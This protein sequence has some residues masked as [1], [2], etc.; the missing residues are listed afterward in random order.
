MSEI[1]GKSP[2]RVWKYLLVTALAGVL[3]A[4]GVVWYATTDSFQAM[5][6]RRLVTELEKI[7]GGRVEIGSFHTIPFRLRVEV[8][9]ITIHGRESADEV[10]YAHADS[11]GAQVKIISVLG[12]ELGF[13][14]LV[15]DH[16][17]VHI[18][19]YPDGSNNQPEP[20]VQRAYEKAPV[21][22]LFSLSISQLDVRDGELVW[23][24]QRIPLDF[25]A[26]D[27][28]ASMSYALFRRRYDGHIAVGKVDSR[29]TD[30]RPFAWHAE[31]D[32]SL[33]RRQID[34]TSFKWSSG[35][36]HLEAHGRLA[37]FQR[38]KIEAD[39]TGTL[40]LA[41]VASILRRRELRQG[42][43]DVQGRGEWSLEEFSSQG[44]FQLR[45]L[46]WRD[47][48]VSLRGARLNSEF[49][50]TDK[51][52]K[53][54]QMQARAFG[55]SGVGD[56][57]VANWLSPTP[58][59]QPKNAKPRKPAEEQRGLLRLR[60]KGLSVTLVAAAFTT[61]SR[62]FDR[63][64]L[65]G[66][67]DATIDARWQGSIRDTEVQ[68]ALDV[69]PPGRGS[70]PALPVTAKARFMYRAG[71]QEF[72]VSEFSARTPGSQLDVSGKLSSTSSLRIVAGT[73]N[74]EEWRPVI[75]SLH[76]PAEI[77]ISLHGHATFNGTAT[78]RLSALT[79][80]GNLQ[81]NNFS[82]T[83]PASSR[84]PEREI[85]WDSFAANVQISATSFAVHNAMLH[86]AG[87]DIHFE[88][89]GGLERGQLSDTS[90]FLAHVEIR[91]GDLAEIE[92]LAG[93]DYPIDGSLNLTLQASGTKL[94]PHGEGHIQLANATLYGEPVARFTSDLRFAKGEVELNN[95]QSE[96]YGGSVN[97]SAA[98]NLDA[99]DFHF[100]LAGH[101][102]DLRRIQRIQG[103]RL[104]VEGGLDATVQG[105]G[106]LQEPVINADIELHDL[107]LDQERAGDYSI[108]A[109]TKGT[110]FHLSGR[111]HF[112]HSDLS[113]DGD[114]K[115]RN[116][117]PANLTL[118]FDHLDVDSLIRARFAGRVTGHSA[119]AGEIKLEGPLRQPAQLQATGNLS[120][121]FVDVEDLK[122]SNQGPIRFAVKDQTL[123]L[124]QLH[125]VGDLTDFSAQGTAQ[126]A[127][128]RALDLRADGSVGL[129][130][131][132][133]FNP[134]FTAAGNV[135]MNLT[136]SGTAADPIVQ[137]RLQVIG[138]ALSYADLPSGLSD[139]Q[140]SLVFNQ[141]RM[142]IE[143]LSAHTGGGTVNVGGFIAY[144]RRQFSFDLT[145]HGQDV[146]LRYPP[147]V[148]STANADVRLV[149]STS[150]ASLTGDV[151]VNKLTITPGFDFGS[152]LEKSKQSPSIPSSNSLLNNVR[153][154]IHIVT[155]PDLQMQTAMAK[156]SGDAD[157]RL[158]SSAARPV[159]LGRVDILE[160]EVSFNGS[161]YRLDRGDVTF[162]NPVRIEPVLDL[163][164]STR[165]SDYD[166][167]LGLNGTVDKLNINYRSE[168]PLPSSDIIA[169]LAMGRTREESASLQGSSGFSQEASNLILSEA[170]NSFVSN[171]AQRLFGVSR[172]KVD[173]N[174]PGT[175][176]SIVT[177]APQVTIE[178][179][180]A[181][182]LVLTYST[183][184][185]QT[186]QQ[187]IQVEY[188]L[189]RNVSIVA[190][191]D[192]N[193]VVS[194]DVKVRKRKK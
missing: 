150:A 92:A 141:E 94:L 11:F 140:G 5:V 71:P 190:L 126:L 188:A 70:P 20:K 54:S 168:P 74:L 152:Y 4:A 159:L 26:N 144:Y 86:H 39:Y 179:Q 151:L 46:D 158:R 61:K 82:S 62:P 85:H 173:P 143:T 24:N 175:E 99:K 171:R 149:G 128:K 17:V 23:N 63:E 35:P 176:T 64:N 58:P 60:I 40:D 34:V 43:I 12:A 8:R 117:W 161:K 48:N 114:V 133:T 19:V 156:L 185:S 53:L 2:R 31:A 154:D 3:A 189:T 84:T 142:Q 42:V 88:V 57:E 120:G 96:Y 81:I 118:H 138:G 79:L 146:R 136:V 52:L 13:Q 132:E 155:T 182:S 36:S 165:V 102:F 22:R 164:A 130:L 67:A 7:T 16:P 65:I 51:Q 107:T 100:N 122:L 105:S 116:E 167:T 78:G 66:T 37:D 178:Q 29:I 10:P 91:N 55:G 160:G 177:S 56:L 112:V 145:A 77:P 191:R 41:D 44:K 25:V 101:H 89:S 14:S 115:L 95:I 76:G 180:V 124:E 162:T 163:Q 148:S 49:W 109:T 72:E 129:K 111:S 69:T 90:P 93:Y 1:R 6:R 45:D 139:M 135:V 125:L 108:V 97:G 47:E 186:S 183:N 103:A 131:I 83:I 59:A 27:F 134:D 184:V 113:I 18:I 110:D 172:I 15:V 193:G 119:M 30:F 50:V 127:G 187:I 192:Y 157:L 123:A 33:G 181:S 28:S 32:L 106:T 121:F 104:T 98:Y 87:T 38:P 169:L 21:E 75:T 174:G 80:A 194:F 73:T 9:N 137:G 170:L 153:M 68:V 147:G 166:I